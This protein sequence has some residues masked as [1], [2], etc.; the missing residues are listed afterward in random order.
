MIV[1]LVFFYASALDYICSSITN[2]I[3]S[4]LF[5]IIG[6]VS[7]IICIKIKYSFSIKS[8]IFIFILFFCSIA[9]MMQLASGGFPWHYKASSLTILYSLLLLV[10]WIITYEVTYRLKVYHRVSTKIV[11]EQ[12]YK[13]Y[14]DVILL[15]LA[16][17]STVLCIK[18]YGFLNL[19]SRSISAANV[20]YNDGNGLPLIMGHVIRNI[21]ILVFS[22]ELMRYRKLNFYIFTSFFCTIITKFPTGI[23]RF[24]MAV[25]YI[26]LT[27]TIFPHFFKRN[28]YFEL[29]LSIGLL[30]VFPIINIFRY[31]SLDN[32]SIQQIVDYYKGIREIFTSGDFDAFSMFVMTVENI[33]K[34]GP[35]WGAIFGSLFF[36]VPRS[37]WTTK[38]V[39]SGTYLAEMQG[40]KFDN[41]SCPIFAEGYLNGGILGLLLSAFIFAKISKMLDAF[42]WEDET[43]LREDHRFIDFVYPYLLGYFF[44]ICRGAL[45]SCFAYT[46]G[47]LCTALLVF[48]LSHTAK[49][50]KRQNV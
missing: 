13:T 43:I 8:F 44:T 7:I 50:S 21:P 41:L 47:F 6:L 10:A 39:G 33:D 34:H 49:I 16:V 4:L 17:G 37:I 14:V 36:F 9:P 28:K 30:Y 24:N 40:L 25:V 42:Y 22:M 19:F 18:Y 27:V 15:I 38:P 35:I 12:N 11:F 3:N 5:F 32:I 48:L 29:I 46:I 45:I 31:V 2:F 1:G 26:G 20:S 23:G